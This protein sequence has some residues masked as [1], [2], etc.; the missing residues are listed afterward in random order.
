MR[1]DFQ[2]LVKSSHP[3]IIGWIRSCIF[4]QLKYPGGRTDPGGDN[5]PPKTY[6]SNFIHH[7]FGQF[8]KQHSR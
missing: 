8:G 3:N 6:E 2:I 4:V 1:L 7:D 5:C